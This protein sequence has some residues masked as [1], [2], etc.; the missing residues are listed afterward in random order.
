MLPSTIDSSRSD[1]LDM[2]TSEESA[3]QH[4]TPPLPRVMPT[5]QAAATAAAQLEQL[6]LA[7]DES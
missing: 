6:S 1:A 7:E 5:A 4:V 3:L 2:S